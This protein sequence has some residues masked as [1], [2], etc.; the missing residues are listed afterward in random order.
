VRSARY[1]P[2]GEVPSVTYPSGTNVVFTAPGS[3]TNG[4]YGLFEW[5]MSGTRGGADPHFHT[6]FSESFY[7]PAGTVSLFNGETWIDA[8]QGTFLYVPPGGGLARGVGAPRPVPGLNSRP[9][10]GRRPGV[11]RRR[12]CLDDLPINN[13]LIINRVFELR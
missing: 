13:H 2:G 4:Q 3:A 10:R 5:N 12:A 9:D 11:A 7:V 8:A 1:R 6:T